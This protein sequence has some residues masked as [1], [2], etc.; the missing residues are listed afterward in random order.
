M[1]VT[2][3]GEGDNSINRLVAGHAPYEGRR[4]RSCSVINLLRGG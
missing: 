4:I 2:I 1:L 3:R